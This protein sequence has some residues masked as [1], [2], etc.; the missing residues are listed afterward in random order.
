MRTGAS[1]WLP[2]WA[3]VVTF[4]M[5]SDVIFTRVLFVVACMY[6]TVHHMHRFSR[7]LARLH[8]CWQIMAVWWW[9]WLPL[10]VERPMKS[11]LA[12]SCLAQLQLSYH[13][14]VKVTAARNNP[15]AGIVNLNRKECWQSS[16][17]SYRKIK[18]NANTTLVSYI[19]R[20]LV[21]KHCLR[22]LLK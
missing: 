5:T 21:G 2:V 1:M 10:T 15:S 9:R 4:P 6:G 18:S 14:Y 12:S 20:Q 11:T 22:I 8:I 16:A 13:G 3:A 7:C 19:V 17:V